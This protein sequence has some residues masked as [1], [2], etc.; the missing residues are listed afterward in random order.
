M[1]LSPRPDKPIENLRA[2]MLRGVALRAGERVRRFDRRQNSLGGTALRERCERA[3][4]I[5]RFVFDAADAHQQ[6]M[7]GTD[8]RIVEAGGH[9]VRFLDLPV[10]VLQQQRVAALQDAGRAVCERSRVL[11]EPGAFAACFQAEHLHVAIGDERM[12]QADRVGT[13]ADAGDHDVRQLAGLRERSARALRG[14]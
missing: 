3:V 8:A 9:R 11:A 6:R 13:A 7:L 14:R 5:H 1:S 4:V 2:G 10:L 12:E